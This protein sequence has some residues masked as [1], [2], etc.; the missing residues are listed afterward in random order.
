MKKR[1]SSLTAEG[2]AIVRAV[3][4]Q[5]PPAERLCDDPLA[6]RLV[7]PVLY[8]LFRPFYGVKAR[9]APGV[10]EFLPLRRRYMDDFLKACLG[11][12]LEQLVILGAGLDSRAYR[13]PG[14]EGHVRVFEVDHPASQ[15]VKV[16]RVR[17]V[18]ARLL[19]HVTYVAVD[20]AEQTLA[21]RLLASGYDPRLKTLTIWEGVTPY[22]EPEAVDATLAFVAG[23]SPPGSWL[24]FDYIYASA[25]RRDSG[26][27]EVAT[28][29]RQQRFSGE[30]LV[31]GLEPGEKEIY[32]AL[33]ASSARSAVKTPRYAGNQPRRTAAKRRLMA[34]R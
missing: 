8:W 32:S 9:S 33:S 7:S 13:I 12:G 18:F 27:P 1:Q 23:S 29:R 21:Q 4:A 24:I 17:K 28:M 16:R 22:L 34:R 2:I 11:Q 15:A 14:L 31:F 5:R 3:E 19:G 25:L 30:G 10:A 26:R 6:R 20:F